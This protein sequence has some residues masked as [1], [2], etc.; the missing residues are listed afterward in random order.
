VIW[1]DAFPDEGAAGHQRWGG[2]PHK[3]LARGFIQ[4]VGLFQGQNGIKKKEYNLCQFTW[5]ALY[6]VRSYG[7][8]YIYVSKI[9]FRTTVDISSFYHHDCIFVGFS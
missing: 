7:A 3:V 6:L 1:A 8:T 5:V 9:L 2:Q 4:T